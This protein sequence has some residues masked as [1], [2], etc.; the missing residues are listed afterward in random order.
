MKAI[1][2][3]ETGGPEVMR[4][5]EI[6]IPTPAEGQVLIRVHASGV[7]FLDIYQRT[8][9]YKLPLPA[10]LGQEGAGVVEKVGPGVNTL[11]V[12]DRVAFTSAQG[13]YA[14]YAVWPA[15]LVAKL[16]DKVTFEQGAATMLQ[17]MTAHYLTHSTF[18]LEPGHTVLL[19]AAAGG[20]GSLIS[21][22][23]KRLGARVIGTVG[24]EE[25]A[26]IARENGT[27]EV[28]N[29]QTQDF[30]AEVK[31]L[32]AGKGVDVVYDSVGR[33]TFE[34]SLNSLRPRG[35]MVTFGNSS[36]PVPEIAPLILSQ[37][38]SLFLTRPTLVHYIADRREFD[39][40]AQGVFEGLISGS[41]RVRIHKKYPLA[42][43]PKA[44]AELESRKS[45]GKLVLVP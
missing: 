41:L 5:D 45:M 34:K 10:T 8:G 22:M 21:Q 15:R 1:R 36:G 42:D 9:L 25:K 23:A 40:R 28:I 6:D 12:G 37:K 4:L 31:R 39:W 18:P 43:A 11:Q 20:T 17:G 24:S 16:P 13:S 7:N 32:T 27:D 19:H 14:E 33:S 44:H 3:H 35:M 29:Y 2:I 30:E 26:K 38:G